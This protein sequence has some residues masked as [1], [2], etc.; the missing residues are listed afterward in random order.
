MKKKP[1]E[2]LKE[3]TNGSYEDETNIVAAMNEFGKQCF[4][5]GKE[6]ELIG[7]T[8]DER[9]H[10]KYKDYGDYLRKLYR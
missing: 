4:D 7:N 2:L 8:G 6:I 9:E 3:W 5:A 10:P 1:Q